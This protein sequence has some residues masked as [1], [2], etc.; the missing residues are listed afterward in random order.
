MD[1]RFKLDTKPPNTAI[2][3][4]MISYAAVSAVLFTPSMPKLITLLHIDKVQTQALVT[5][6]LLGYGLGQLIY[7][8]LANRFGRKVALV[9]GLVLAVFGEL[10]CIAGGMTT[11][12]TTL[13]IGR[14]I[15]ACGA[16]AG[17]TLTFAIVTDYYYL[18][19]A[20]KV[21]ASAILAF[22]VAPGIGV[23]IGGLIATYLSWQY[24]FIA[25]A[26][27]GS[28]LCGFALCLP[29]TSTSLD[30]NSFK[31][32]NIFSEYISIFQSR[33]FILCSLLSAVFGGYV[34]VYYAAGPFI[35]TH[36]FHMPPQIYGFASLIASAGYLFGNIFARLLAK[37]YSAMSVMMTGAKVAL[38]G[39]LILLLMRIGWLTWPYG[40]FIA[41]SIMIT[42]GAMIL[43]NAAALGISKVNNVAIGSAML[44]CITMLLGPTTTVTLISYIGKGH[45]DSFFNIC[46][47]L[48]VV[49]I[50]LLQLV[51]RSVP[52]D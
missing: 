46:L 12:Y 5:I 18:T 17:Y 1:S 8:P 4:L 16:C 44:G 6:F 52:A 34:Y 14:F 13:A 33:I 32:K 41:V 28:L 22:A 36:D 50:V 31:L 49:L 43:S 37:Q 20:R 48:F 9:S 42:G 11:S 38:C 23:A 7:G 24:C 3:I 27:Y 30:R 40:F 47:G 2:L 19:D 15:A 35:A 51:K 45:I 39:L 10:L 26:I 29:E 25:L 21:L